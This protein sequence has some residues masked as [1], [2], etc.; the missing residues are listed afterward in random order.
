MSRKILLVED[1]DLNMR[2][3]RDILEA[4]GHVV[5]CASGVEDAR[6]CFAEASIDLVLMDI[7]IVGGRGEDLLRE[8]RAVRRFDGVPVIAVTA[9]AMDGDRA[10]FLSLGFDEYVSKPIDTRAIGP[11]VDR[12]LARTVRPPYELDGV[13]R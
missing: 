3:L 13:E 11:L 6:K 4:R 5:L 2:L 1:N 7:Q 9:Y 10:R 8:I 12:Y